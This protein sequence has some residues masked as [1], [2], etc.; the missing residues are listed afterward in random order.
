MKHSSVCAATCAL[1]LL[2]GCSQSP[3]KLLTAANKYHQNKKYQEASIL[4]RKV[5]LKDKTNAEAYYREGLNLLD[6]AKVSEAA[7]YLRRAVDLRPSNTDAAVKLSEIYLAAYSQDPKKFK[8]LLSDVRDLDK[9]ILLQD[10]NSFDGLRIQGLLQIAD[11]Q[12]DKAAVTLGK[13][14]RIKP[15]ARNL[16]G[17]Y[18]EALVANNNIPEAVNLMEGMVAHDK[19]FGAG[20]DFLFLQHGRAGERD[21]AE[22]VLRDR[23][24]NDPASAVGYQNLANYLLASNRAAEAEKVMRQLLDDKKSFPS[25]HEMVGDFY[26][27]AKKYEQALAEYQQGEKEDPKNTVKYQE[28]IVALHAFSGRTDQAFQMAKS[29]AEKNPKDLSANE[30]YASLLLQ[31]GNKADATKSL[32]ELKKLAANNPTDPILHLDLAR[33]YFGLNDRDKALSEALEVLQTERKSNP[34]VGV[35]VPARIVAARIYEDRGLHAKA[36]EQ[37]NQVLAAQAGNPDAILIRCRAL[38]GTNEM[39]KALPELEELVKK[40]PKMNDARLQLGSLYL[41]Q[42]Q[43]DKAEDQFQQVSKASPPDIRG[44]LGIQ[45]IRLATGKSAQALQAMQDL[46]DKNPTN[47]AYRYQM[48]NFQATAA[49]MEGA[50]NVTHAKYLIQQ[51]ADNYKEILKTSPNSAD[52]WM[53]LGV[54]QRQLGQFDAALASFEQAGSADSKNAEAFLNRAML[55]E[56]LGKKT[57]AHDAYNKVLALQPENALALNNLA[58][59]NADSGTNLDQA[60]TFAQRAKQKAPNNPDVSDTLGYVYYQKNLNTEAV[61]IFRQNVQDHPQNSMFHFHLAMAL[62]KQGDKEGARE[63]ATK[64][65]ANAVPAQQDKIRSFVNQIG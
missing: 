52:L 15:Y 59:L 37:T 46:V 29:L 8:T 23:V 40:F 26:V 53:R 36:M 39:D 41:A 35:I 38:I 16:V 43:Y 57:E 65:L 10:A 30:M 25:G 12:Y 1:V 5:L 55:F 11:Q 48:A 51:A 24:K 4:Y 18:A 9:K 58:Y 49:G 61:R 13:A 17:W 42:R 20:Y 60:M 44:F 7:S 32:G 34:R 2:A 21:K 56:A 22:A 54:M 3:E 64:A 50:S 63:E 14:N 62:L 33:A 45:T 47:T 6:Q 19:T 28:R 27:R 31:S